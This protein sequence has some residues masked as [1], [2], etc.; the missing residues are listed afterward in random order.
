MNYDHGNTSTEY[1]FNLNKA[2][3]GR[4]RNTLWGR[5]IQREG[6]MGEIKSV[7]YRTGN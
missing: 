1:W 2:L 3:Y 4:S 6:I 5:G 7:L